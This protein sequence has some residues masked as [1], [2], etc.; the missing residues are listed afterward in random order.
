MKWLLL[1]FAL[2]AQASIE[3]RLHWL[4]NEPL[5]GL[6]KYESA[7][8]PTLE[9][10]KLG[11]LLF[12]DKRLSADGTVSCSSCHEVGHAYS[13]LTSVATGIGGVKGTRKAPP[14]LNKAFT[15]VFFWDGR[16][17][18]LE[19]QAQGPL[20]HPEEMGMTAEKLIATLNGMDGY[21]ELFRAAF[22]ESEITLAR[23][24]G[25]I[26][27]FERTL[28]SG[29]SLWD[30]WQASPASVV[31]PKE[32]E[33]GYELFQDRD[34]IFCH[35]PPF[36]TDSLFH[37][38]GMGFHDGQF[39]DPGRFAISKLEKDLGAFKTPTL[40]NV[41]QH[42][43]Y[44]HDGTVATL[45]GVVE[46]YNDGGI[47]NPNIDEKITRLGLAPDERAAIVAFLM[48]L[49]GTGFE[50]TPPTAAEFPRRSSPP[51]RRAR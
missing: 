11:R 4:L 22:G 36:F 10:A 31:Y 29:N 24:T 41:S 44:M 5:A 50:E 9:R 18:S 8:P 47:E 28:L 48:T 23:V 16:A 43:P 32:A 15:S 14:I 2:P 17:S 19:E 21:R 37:N 20:F 40:R 12:Y 49:D 13:S 42:A 46:F 30:R 25:A 33:R 51:A 26:G 34:C 45:A 1:L 35:V 38:T 7:T 3:E 39:K 6:P 27:D